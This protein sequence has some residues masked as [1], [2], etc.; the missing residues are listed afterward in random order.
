[1][2]TGSLDNKEPLAHWGLLCYA[3]KVYFGGVIFIFTV[4]LRSVLFGCVRL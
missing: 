2:L 3:K 4:A 1:M